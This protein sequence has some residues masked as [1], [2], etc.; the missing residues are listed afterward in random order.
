MCHWKELSLDE[1]TAADFSAEF[2][3]FMLGFTLTAL[4]VM[5]GFFYSPMMNKEAEQDNKRHL[6]LSS[7]EES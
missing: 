5:Q 6:A 2:D 1:S 7:E 4:L 3:D